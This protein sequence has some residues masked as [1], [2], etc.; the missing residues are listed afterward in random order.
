MTRRS[1]VERLLL[2]IQSGRVVP[3]RYARK[4]LRSRW[5]AVAVLCAMAYAAAALG[6]AFDSLGP[7]VEP[8]AR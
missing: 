2:E 7:T 6:A 5:A 8:R 3:E 4:S 1:V